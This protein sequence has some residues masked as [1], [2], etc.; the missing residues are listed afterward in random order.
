MVS[1]VDPGPSG[2]GLSFDGGHCVVFLGKTLDCRR[3]FLCFPLFCPWPFFLLLLPPYKLETWNML[4][5]SKW[6]DQD[7]IQLQHR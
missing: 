7:S 4:L 2:S 5:K 3:P 1:A 6:H